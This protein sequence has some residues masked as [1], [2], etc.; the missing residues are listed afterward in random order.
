MTTI[1]RPSRISMVPDGV[2]SEA[3]SGVSVSGCGIGGKKSSVDEGGN[4]S[5]MGYNAGTSALASRRHLNK[6]RGWH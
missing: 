1:A 4:T 5:S 2:G 6:R 3:V